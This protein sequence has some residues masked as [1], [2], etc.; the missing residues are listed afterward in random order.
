MDLATLR[1]NSAELD[2]MHTEAWCVTTIK[3]DAVECWPEP[4]TIGQQA[5]SVSS[6]VGAPPIEFGI[7]ICMTQ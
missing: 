7:A 6:S 3:R 2:A 1:A 5:L 4:R